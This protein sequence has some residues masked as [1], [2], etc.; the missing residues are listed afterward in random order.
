[1]GVRGNALTAV[2]IRTRHFLLRSFEIERYF[3]VRARFFFAD[4]EKC[5][6]IKFK[7]ENSNPW[8]KSNI[9]LREWKQQS[10]KKSNGETHQPISP[11]PSPLVQILWVTRSV[12]EGGGGLK[13]VFGSKSQKNRLRRFLPIFSPAAAYKQKLKKLARRRKKQKTRE[14]MQ[15]W[16][17]LCFLDSVTFGLFFLESHFPS[18]TWYSVIRLFDLTARALFFSGPD[19]NARILINFEWP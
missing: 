6:N 7:N 12:G 18:W 16:V 5:A 17:I 2:R 13:P 11:S 9:I 10:L 8:K 3:C 4:I 1:M 14:T 15:D 19:A